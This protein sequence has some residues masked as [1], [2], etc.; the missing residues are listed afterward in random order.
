MEFYRLYIY[1]VLV[2][3]I[4]W[5]LKHSNLI[6]DVPASVMKNKSLWRLLKCRQVAWMLLMTK[7]V[8]NVWQCWKLRIKYLISEKTTSSCRKCSTSL[9]CMSDAVVANWLWQ[10]LELILHKT[11]ESRALGTGQRCV[12]LGCKMFNYWQLQLQLRFTN[13]SSHAMPGTGQ[14]TSLVTKREHTRA[15]ILKNKCD[16]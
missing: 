5:V 7:H 9:I 15:S 1:L 10:F 3:N 4:H 6:S 16:N 13:Q 12:E 14:C 2:L 8:R 11:R